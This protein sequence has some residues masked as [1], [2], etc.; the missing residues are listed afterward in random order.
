MGLTI[1]T[2]VMVAETIVTDAMM[3]VEIVTY[4]IVIMRCT[5]AD[6]ILAF[7]LELEELEGPSF[8]SSGFKTQPG[9]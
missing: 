4:S 9:A 8:G 7:L 5:S 3:T 1:V 6:T 2:E